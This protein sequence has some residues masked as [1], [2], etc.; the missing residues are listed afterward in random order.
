MTKVIN[1]WSTYLVPNKEH[2]KATTA[3]DDNLQQILKALQPGTRLLQNDI[4]KKE[5][6]QEWAKGRYEVKYGI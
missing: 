3:T 1:Q 2:W 6:F 4:H 5:Y